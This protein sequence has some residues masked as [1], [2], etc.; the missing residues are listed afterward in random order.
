[1]NTDKTRKAR[2]RFEQTN[3]ISFQD[4]PVNHF[5]VRAQYL[6]EITKDEV[7][8]QWEESYYT[9]KQQLTD[10][11]DF[12]SLSDKIRGKVRLKINKFGQITHILN[13]EELK[14]SWETAKRTELLENNLIKKAKNTKNAEYQELLNEGDE[15]FSDME[16]F[17]TN[18]SVYLYFR[19][20]LGQYLQ[21]PFEQ[22]EDETLNT[23]AFLFSG[24]PLEVQLHYSKPKISDTQVTIEQTGKVDKEKL[25][26][27]EMI[28]QYNKYYKSRIR[29][30]FTEYDYDYRCTLILNKQDGL[31]DSAEVSIREIIK[32]NVTYEVIFSLKRVEL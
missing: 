2:Y 3:I 26:T 16:L 6:F 19:V 23:F 4:I 28:R 24:F 21:V 11:E 18:M 22:L 12:L 8:S 7:L 17:K 25:D 27:L 10:L 20:I 31:L 1:M 32:N 9:L 5:T 30:N 13:P 15:E 14:M 29:Y